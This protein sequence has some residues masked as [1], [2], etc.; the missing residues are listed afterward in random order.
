M[1]LVG[2]LSFWSLLGLIVVFDTGSRPMAASGPNPVNAAQREIL[3]FERIISLPREV[4]GLAWSPDG[5]QVLVRM[6]W[7]GAFRLVDVESGVVG[8]PITKILGHDGDFFYS[9]NGKYLVVPRTKSLRLFRFPNLELV[10]ELKGPRN[11]KE[12]EFCGFQVWF[13]AIFEP[14]GKSI[15]ASCIV[16]GKGGTYLTAVKVSIPDLKIIDRLEVPPP[17]IGLRYM[18]A[19]TNQQNRFER[20][21]EEIYILTRWRTSKGTFSTGY[22][23][24]TKK[25]LFPSI[26]MDELGFG[27]GWRGGNIAYSRNSSRLFVSRLQLEGSLYKRTTSRTTMKMLDA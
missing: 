5:K 21:G 16:Q 19:S 18:G 4:T 3:T 8:Q 7:T 12:E 10:G 23:L 1:V 9:P 6:S 13:G 25:R 26:D 11:T 15:W 27:E 20:R 14:D 22:S 24:R 17:V 2:V